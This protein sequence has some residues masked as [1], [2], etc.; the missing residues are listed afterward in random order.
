MARKIICGIY[1]IE[2]TIDKK[3]YIG[4]SVDIYKRWTGHKNKLDN[5]KHQNNHLQRAWNLYG[6]NNFRFDIL[7]ECFKDLLNERECYYIELMHSMDQNHGYNLTSGGSSKMSYSKETINKM[8]IAKKGKPLSDEHKKK[9]SEVHK[10][11]VFSEE[12]R[13]KLSEAN[14]GHEVSE[15]TR[16]KLRKAHSGKKLS[17]ESKEKVRKTRI[18]KPVIQF[19]KN[20]NFIREYESVALAGQINNI[21]PTNI[22]AGC[23]G[24]RKTVRGFIWRY[25][26]EYMQQLN[27]IDLNK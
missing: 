3:V 8:S 7:E 19:D 17:E 10:G 4:Q 5:N 12:T 1:K 21:P 13:K 18:K 15:E 23:K 11:R 25:K 2:N 16:E 6:K 14:M 26:D 27:K 20:G 22:S 9:L 24:K